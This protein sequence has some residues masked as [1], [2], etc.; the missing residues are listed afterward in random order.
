M[1]SFPSPEK[2]LSC[3]GMIVSNG[4]SLPSEDF[5][6]S[7]YQVTKLFC[8]RFLHHLRFLQ[9]ALSSRFSWLLR[10]FGLS[11]VSTS[12]VF[13]RYHFLGGSES[14]S[15]EVLAGVSRDAGTLSSTRFSGEVLQ[16]FWHIE[17]QVSLYRFGVLICFCF[18]WSHATGLPVLEC[19]CSVFVWLLVWRRIISH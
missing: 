13:P 5:V 11:E 2:F 17:Q 12:T 19:V 8:S 4:D 6:I 14:H 16:P 18:L 7:R 9:T 3:T 10:N 15:R 1:N